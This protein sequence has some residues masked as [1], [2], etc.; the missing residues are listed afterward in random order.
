MINNEIWEFKT[1]SAGTPNSIHNG[2]KRGSEQADNVLIH[3][4]K[5]MLA[6]DLK[7]AIYNRVRQ[8]KEPHEIRKLCIIHHGQLHE[9][10]RATIINKE[11]L[12]TAQKGEGSLT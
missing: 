9:F 12:N 5:P 6:T 3:L 11:F 2:I 7:N 4:T 8:C 10:T 1:N